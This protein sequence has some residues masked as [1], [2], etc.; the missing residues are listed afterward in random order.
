MDQVV[1][2]ALAA[3]KRIAKAHEARAQTQ[4]VGSPALA[5]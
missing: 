3:F 1:A 2:Q 4:Q 5:D